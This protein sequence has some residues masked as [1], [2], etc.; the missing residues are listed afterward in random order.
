MCPVGPCMGTR[1]PAALIASKGGF[2]ANFVGELHCM[3]NST[4]SSYMPVALKEQNLLLESRPFNLWFV[5]S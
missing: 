1:Q 5:S 3:I 2:A 4:S